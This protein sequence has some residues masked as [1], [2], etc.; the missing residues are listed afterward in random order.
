MCEERGYLPSKQAE[1]VYNMSLC[2]FVCVSACWSIANLVY[3]NQ[4]DFTEGWLVK[5]VVVIPIPNKVLY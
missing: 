2:V 1:K 3:L 5:H 4:T